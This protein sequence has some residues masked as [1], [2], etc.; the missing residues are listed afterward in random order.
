MSS[1]TI[2]DILMLMKKGPLSALEI[3]IL[4]LEEDA[5]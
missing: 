1:S 5:L 3:M 2:S 4:K